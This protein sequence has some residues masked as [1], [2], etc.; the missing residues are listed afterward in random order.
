MKKWLLIIT[1][2]LSF[3]MASAQ[4]Y[5]WA[6]NAACI[7]YTNCTKC[8]FPGGPGPFSLID[9]G[10]AFT[11][12]FAIK[13][14]VLADYMPPWPPD[15]TYQ[16][17]AHERLLT[18]EEKDILVAWVDQGGQQGNLANAPIPPS[19]SATGSQLATINFSGGIGNFTNLSTNDQYRSFL[20]PTHFATDQYVSHIELVPGTRSMVHHVLIFA[21]TDTNALIS[22]DAGD[23][24]LGWQS[25]GGIGGASAK[26]IG[27]YVPGQGPI[28]FP[29]GMGVRIAAGSYFVLQVHYPQGTNGDVDSNTTINL[30]FAGG[31]VREVLLQPLLNHGL[32]I[33]PSLNIPANSEMDFVETLTLPS[34]T[35]LPD[36]F[37]VLSV[38]PHMH[39]VGTSIKA[40]AIKPG[41]DTVPLVDIPQWDFNWQGSYDF[42][43]PIVLPEGTVLKA[44]AHYNNTSSNPWAPNPNA[45]VHAGEATTDEMMIVFFGF[46]YGFP[47]DENIIVD[48]TTVKPTYMGC[49]FQVGE[50]LIEANAKLQL[51]PNPTGYD[52]FIRYEQLKESDLSISIMDITGRTVFSL[53]QQQVE[54]GVYEKNIQVESLAPGTYTVH[55]ANNRSVSNKKLIIVR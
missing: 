20:V 46:T 14:A 19:Y 8:H 17:H 45:S 21:D 38:S 7:F 48:T 23:P 36:N 1:A 39:L 4:T 26:L 35:P 11:A 10:N 37:T 49:S 52:F 43:Q 13:A 24:Q 55:I 28:T 44:E 41:N 42:R 30:T 54:A 31:A 34:I 18:Q 5:T 32:N 16:T 15:P 47:G 2:V 29:A 6:E 51:Y 50:D 9:Y 40:Y 27:V 33:S 12:R 22:A 25:G 53:I 3:K